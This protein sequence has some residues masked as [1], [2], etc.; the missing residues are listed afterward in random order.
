M[1]A[2]LFT[3][4][5]ASKKLPFLLKILYPFSHPLFNLF[6]S[7]DGGNSRLSVGTKSNRSFF[8]NKK[9]VL[10][11][12]TGKE[13]LLQYYKNIGLGFKTL[14]KAMEGT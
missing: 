1:I 14:K 10:L 9:M 3:P 11:R 2:A 5:A 12:E 6:C 8:Q 7:E 4:V 13:K